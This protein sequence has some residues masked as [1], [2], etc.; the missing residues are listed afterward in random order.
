[1]EASN[2]LELVEYLQNNL[3]T[4]EQLTNKEL[5]FLPKENIILINEYISLYN[6][7]LSELSTISDYNIKG[8]TN[9]MVIVSRGYL[10]LLEFKQNQ[11]TYQLILQKDSKGYNS[12]D[13]SKKDLRIKNLLEKYLKDTFDYLSNLPKD[14]AI[15]LG[16]K[17]YERIAVAAA[18][19]GHIEI[20]EWM[21]ELG[22]NNYQLIAYNAA[23][24]GHIE[25]LKRMIELGAKIV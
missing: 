15:Q 5:V 23:R 13:Y 10:P 9:L 17:N 22:A 20:V 6:G 25:I 2:L 14:V 11:L 24:G 7:N 1:M 4:I 18:Y 8:I 21:V 19:D 3:P 12:L 16:A